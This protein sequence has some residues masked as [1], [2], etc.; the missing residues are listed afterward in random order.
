MHAQPP[1][2]CRPHGRV[3]ALAV[4]QEA[5]VIVTRNGKHF[6]EAQLREIGIR[7]MEPD[8]FVLRL[9][10]RKRAAVLAAAE[11]HRLSLLSAPLAPEHYL[12]SL[13]T[14]AGLPRTARKLAEPGFGVALS[15]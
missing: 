6:P 9:L 10:K 11:R 14:H 4:H 2:E 12:E 13:R 8:Q 3:I 1:L 15:V 5:E 7:P